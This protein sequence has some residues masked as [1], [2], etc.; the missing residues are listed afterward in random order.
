[1]IIAAVA[2][3]AVIA[4]SQLSKDRDGSD[5]AVEERTGASTFNDISATIEKL[6]KTSWNKDLYSKTYI[7]IINRIKANCQNGNIR[8]SEARTLSDKAEL[9]SIVILIQAVAAE[10][11]ACEPKTMNQLKRELDEFVNMGTHN[12]V[13]GFMQTVEN[14]KEYEK[15]QKFIYT[16][17]DLRNK[18]ADLETKFPNAA[19]YHNQ[20]KTLKENN[21]VA[22]CSRIA[23]SLDKVDEELCEAHY[24]FLDKKTDLFIA[25]DFSDLN[26]K[27]EVNKRFASI[28]SEVSEEFLKKYSF[29]PYAAKKGK[30]DSL[31]SKL[32]NGKNKI[33]ESFNEK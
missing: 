5:T 12:G 14:M 2:I 3:A 6:E 17:Y 24:L 31:L 13:S 28:E 30:A 33:I 29:Y 23:G 25:S 7:P 26:S 1:M 16:V 10:I 15:T 8:E 21:F 18:Q 19:Y 11:S 22:K 20:A 4:I 9:A 32:E 27:E